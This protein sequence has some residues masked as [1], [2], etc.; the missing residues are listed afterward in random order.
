ME[1]HSGGSLHYISEKLPTYSICEGRKWHL[2]CSIFIPFGGNEMEA[3]GRE[4]GEEIRASCFK[5]AVK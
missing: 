3:E 4:A 5:D 2:I 1:W